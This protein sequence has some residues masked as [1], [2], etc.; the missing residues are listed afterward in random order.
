M[1]NLRTLRVS[2]G[3]NQ[4][5]LAELSGVSIAMISKIEQG[6]RVPSL[7]LAYKLAK[8]LAVTMEELQG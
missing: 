4:R 5:Q 8:V 2:R 6:S 1:N 3:L 7:K